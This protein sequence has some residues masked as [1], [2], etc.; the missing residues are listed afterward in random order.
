MDEERQDGQLEPIYSSSVLI[1]DIAL[2]TYWEQ[3]TIETCG[4]RGSGICVLAVRH[5]DDDDVFFCK[6]PATML[7]KSVSPS[8]E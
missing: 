1:E 5:D 7:K 8:G 2:K 4:E 6:T 3:W